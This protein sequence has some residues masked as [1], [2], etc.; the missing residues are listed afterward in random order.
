MCV[1]EARRKQYNDDSRRL[2][3]VCRFALISCV[4]IVVLHY[5]AA[6]TDS[7]EVPLSMCV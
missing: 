5:R 2:E 7:H 4:C 1:V 6:T 3:A